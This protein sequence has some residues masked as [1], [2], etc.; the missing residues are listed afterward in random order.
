M[1]KSKTIQAN[2]VRSIVLEME[3]NNRIDYD[4]SYR[5]GT[6]GARCWDVVSALFPTLSDDKSAEVYN[7]LPNRVG[8]WVN[9][10]GGGL[11]GGICR[12]DYSKVLP[13]KYAKRIDAFTRECKNRYLEI[14]NGEG[15]NDEEDAE[16]N[17]NWEA[18][19]TNRSRAAGVERA[20]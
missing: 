5:G 9:Y 8:V 7:L 3:K 1:N 12:S 10:L 18:L 15:L 4:I 17:T 13:A 19:G 16:G 14:E 11:R 20:Y 2:N 6:Y